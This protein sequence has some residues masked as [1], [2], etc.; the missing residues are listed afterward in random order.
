MEYHEEVMELLSEFKENAN[1]PDLQIFGADIPYN[2]ARAVWPDTVELHNMSTE[3]TNSNTDKF[4]MMIHETKPLIRKK[5]TVS[6][7]E[8]F[9]KREN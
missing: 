3:K 1:T 5:S 7:Y 6:I 4:T 2:R 9:E 8:I